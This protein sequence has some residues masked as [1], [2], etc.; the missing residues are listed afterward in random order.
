M[1]KLDENNDLEISRNKIKELLKENYNF[2]PHNTLVF[3]MLT[4]EDPK[5][6]SIDELTDEHQQFLLFHI[7]NRLFKSF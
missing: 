7:H 5:N 3:E 1:K 4:K 6:Y 2:K